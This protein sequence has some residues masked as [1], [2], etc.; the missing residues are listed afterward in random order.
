[1]GRKEV[2]ERETYAEILGKVAEGRGR[3]GINGEKKG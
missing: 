3:N 2:R 1:M